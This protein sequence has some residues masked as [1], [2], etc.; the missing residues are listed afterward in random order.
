MSGVKLFFSDEF[1]SNKE[2]SNALHPDLHS[3]FDIGHIKLTTSSSYLKALIDDTKIKE[4]TTIDDISD[5]FEA[6]TLKECQ[7]S[8]ASCVKDV[9]FGSDNNISYEL[10]ANHILDTA[11]EN[12]ALISKIKDTYIK[13][14][15]KSN[16]HPNFNE[17]IKNIKQ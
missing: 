2:L 6:L 7:M 14:Y 15:K 5:E 4:A 1:D 12:I 10:G 9:V 13:L 11:A 16:T 17:I 8:S 3:I